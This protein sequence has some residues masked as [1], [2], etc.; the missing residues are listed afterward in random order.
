MVINQLRFFLDD[1]P[2][3]FGDAYPLVME[4]HHYEEVNHRMVI[5]FL[6]VMMVMG[7][8]PG[9]ATK[10]LVITKWALFLGFCYITGR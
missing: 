9:N 2:S 3:S 4:H 10:P 7:L 8:S 6:L 5:T 1:P